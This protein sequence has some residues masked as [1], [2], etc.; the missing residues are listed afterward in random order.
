[1]GFLRKEDWNGCYFLLQGIF[2]T[3]GSNLSLLHCRQVLYQLSLQESPS[4]EEEL[5]Q[6][7]AVEQDLIA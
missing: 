7:L 1:M 6:M 4:D 3:Q 5:Q 2:L